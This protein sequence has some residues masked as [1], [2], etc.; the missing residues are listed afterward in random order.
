MAP[1]TAITEGLNKIRDIVYHYKEV[2]EMP[3]KER[4]SEKAKKDYEDRKA[5][6]MADG[7][8]A[9][10]LTCPLCGFNRPLK[11]WGKDTRFIVKPDYAIITVRKGG[12]RR[13]GF[14][15]LEDRD[16]NLTDLWGEFPEVWKNLFENVNVLHDLLWKQY[17]SIQSEENVKLLESLGIPPVEKQIE[18]FYERLAGVPE[19]KQKR[20]TGQTQ[21]P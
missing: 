4:R 6:A 20:K 3:K 13:I 11:M 8:E 10:F 7:K 15:R 2:N 12:G 16:V 14:F 21:L 17:G 9:E 19:E 1:I 5:Q 18:Q